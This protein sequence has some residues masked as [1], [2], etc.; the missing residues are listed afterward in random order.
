LT[1]ISN[2]LTIDVED[3][4]HVN[5]FKEHI[6]KEDWDSHPMRV[7]RTTLDVLDLLDAHGA[8]GTFFV[9]GWVAERNG[10]LVRE[11]LRRG[12]EVACHGYSHEL[13]YHIGPDKFRKDIRRARLLLEDICGEKIRGYR[14][15]SFSITEESLWALDIIIEEGFLYDSSIF[16]ISH[17]VYGMKGAC[18]FPHDIERPAGVIREFPISTIEIGFLNRRIRMPFSGGGY[19]RLIP[20]CLIKKALRHINERKGQPSVLYF[21]P[22]EID[23]DQPRIRAGFRSRCRHYHNLHKTEEKLGR[24][25]STFQF[26]PMGEVLGIS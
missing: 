5:A 20:L 9:L 4:F 6:R 12:H 2:A 10:P 3:Y 22:W 24:L 15:P 14:A 23:P 7:E 16:P 1:T 18:A 19:L 21:H 13:I 17:D 25:L 8:R 11:I 26:L